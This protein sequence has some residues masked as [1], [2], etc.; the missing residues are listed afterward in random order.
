[1]NNR[2]GQQGEFPPFIHSPR[3]VCGPKYAVNSIQNDSDYNLVACRLSNTVD[4]S[5]EA[6]T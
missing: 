2:I 4:S 6:Q 1:M 5:R 3:R